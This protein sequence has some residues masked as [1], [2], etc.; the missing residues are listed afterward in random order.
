MA[1]KSR[2]QSGLSQKQKSWIIAIIVTTIVVALLYWEQ[3]A[4]LYVLATLSVTVLLAVVAFADLSGVKSGAG[5]VTAGVD[6]LPP[7]GPSIGVKPISSS[8]FGARKGKRRS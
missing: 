2:G 7:D 6:P 4:L 1:R 3:I 8:T 5:M